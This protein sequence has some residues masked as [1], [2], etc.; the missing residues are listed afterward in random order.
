MYYISIYTF[1]VSLLC[2]HRRN[3]GTFWTIDRSSSS[4]WR[5]ITPF[6]AWNPLFWESHVSRGRSRCWCRQSTI[7]SRMC[8]RRPWLC[9]RG[10]RLCF[11]CGV[12]LFLWRM[13]AFGKCRVSWKSSKD[14][15][16]MFQSAADKTGKSKKRPWTT[17]KFHERFF[18]TFTS[19]KEC[20]IG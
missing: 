11:V 9:M 3:V 7:S 8:P 1:L 15:F 18:Q 2:A 13:W 17:I 20:M 14:R 16:L 4:G 19:T 12:R 10:S 5:L 6:P